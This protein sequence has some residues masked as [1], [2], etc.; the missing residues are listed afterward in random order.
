MKKLIG[1]TRLLL[2]GL[3]CIPAGAQADY[4]RNN[5][6]FGVS[7]LQQYADLSA[8]FRGSASES[9][10]GIEI[11][12]DKYI[13]HQY[14]L[15]TS[16]GYIKHDSFDITQFMLAGDYLIPL[17]TTMSAF[18]GLSIGTASQKYHDASFSDSATGSVYGAQAGIITYLSDDY[19]IE[20]GL[21]LRQASIT[22]VIDTTPSNS[23]TID[24]LNEGYISLLFMF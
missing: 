19:L 7:I 23:T 16:L 18:V 24:S 1:L 9:G 4:F 22:T 10:S 3:L 13:K 15:K 8:E 21:R 12:L 5:Y 2:L 20:F 6:V 17:K 11:Y 14:R